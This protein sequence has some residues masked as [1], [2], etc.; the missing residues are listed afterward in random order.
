MVGI[1][2]GSDLTNSFDGLG[3]TFPYYQLLLTELLSG[4]IC[5]QS[6]IKGSANCSRM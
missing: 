2:D 4:E 3:V 6:P 5:V 1:C